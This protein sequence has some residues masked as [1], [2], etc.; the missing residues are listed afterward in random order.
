MK[1]NV[2]AAFG[3]A[4]TLLIAGGVGAT[5]WL[6]IAESHRLTQLHQVVT[7]GGTNYVVQ[8]LE[9]T[10]GKTD[11]G[12]VLIVYLRFQNPNIFDVA[13]RRD[14]FVLT[15][16][17]KN[18]FRPSNNAGQPALIGLPANG[19]V[20]REMFSFALP[21][22]SLGGTIRVLVG[23]N[24]WVMLKDEKPFTRTLRSGEFVS[25]RRRQW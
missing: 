18:S 16:R 24:Y 25:F 21:E 12:Y 10:V 15:D 2:N 17:N 5:A 7:Q 3:A 23:Q 11:S 13:L 4:V 8:V 19:V 1:L 6:R 9:T 22:D 14:Q 20:D